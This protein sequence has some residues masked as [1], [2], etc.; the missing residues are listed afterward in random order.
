MKRKLSKIFGV[1]LTV[2]LLLSLILAVAPVSAKTLEWGKAVILKEGTFGLPYEIMPGFDVLD[3]VAAPTDG[4][5]WAVI[6]EEATPISYIYRSTTSGKTWAKRS[7]ADATATDM[8]V[9][10]V[11]PDDSS[12]VVTAQGDKVFLSTEN[13]EAGTWSEVGDTGAGGNLNTIF[14]AGAISCVDISAK[15]GDGYRWMVVGGVDAAPAG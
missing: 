15:D 11:A 4:K 5:L 6:Q 7:P 13:G 2:T 14:G 1:A 12:V 10:A 3:M 8:M 9:I